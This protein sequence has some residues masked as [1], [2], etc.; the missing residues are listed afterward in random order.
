MTILF[1]PAAPA[2]TLACEACSLL[3]DPSD[4][5]RAAHKAWHAALDAQLAELAELRARDDDF[6]D[7]V[8]QG[9]GQV[10]ARIRA[11]P[12]E[13][14]TDAGVAPN[15]I[16]LRDDGDRLVARIVDLGG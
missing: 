2:P 13:L 10:V 14:V 15:V 16:E 3:V 12:L 1:R 6:E 11:R 5:G 7:V 8:D 4:V 9:S